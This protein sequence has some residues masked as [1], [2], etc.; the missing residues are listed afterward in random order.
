MIRRR[1]LSEILVR[2]LA[3]PNLGQVFPGFTNYTPFN[4]VQGT[5]LPINYG[6][7]GRV[8]LPSVSR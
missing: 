4:I 1:V 3:N 7:S 2:R 5:D 6:G 8:Y